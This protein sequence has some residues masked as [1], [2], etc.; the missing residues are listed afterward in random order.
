MAYCQLLQ[1]IRHMQL[2]FDMLAEPSHSLG[3]WS[4]SAGTDHS[5]MLTRG[6][7]MYTWGTG[8]QGQL[9]R[10]GVRLLERDDKVSFQVRL[11]THADCTCY[12]L[13]FAS[14]H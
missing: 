11:F 6:G 14:L 12:Q 1:N 8:R 10:I 5:I 9:G 3:A 2:V 4:A 13:R 7:D